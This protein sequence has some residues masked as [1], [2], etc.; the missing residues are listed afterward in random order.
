MGLSE[1]EQQFVEEFKKIS[2]QE[3]K[4]EK[5]FLLDWKYRFPCLD[6]RTTNTGFDRHYVYHTAW[7]ARILEKTRPKEHV[8]ISSSLFFCSI[9]S[10]F[11]PIKFF[12]FRP[13]QLQ[14]SQLEI[15]S[16]D[17]KKLPFADE[18]ILSLSCMHV[19]EHIGLARYGDELDYDGDLAAVKELKRVVA[20][21][22]QLLFVVPIG[23]SVIQ[24]N[25]HR[26]YR[27]R[28]VIEMFSGFSLQE[29]ALIPDAEQSGGLVYDASEAMADSQN[30]GCGCFWFVKN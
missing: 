8:D 18:S 5:R 9:V 30:Y 22:G 12:D 28:Q 2:E 3:L 29:F 4:T 15:G 20:K 16:A 10:A 25:A 23:K 14:L 24:F 19:V 11:V 26:I 13:P 27:Y 21:N 1:K 17:I 6:D 7:G